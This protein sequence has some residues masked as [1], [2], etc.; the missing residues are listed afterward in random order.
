MLLASSIGLYI[1]TIYVPGVDIPLNLRG[2]ALVVIAL[3]LINLLIR[4]IV[5]L[6]FTPIII[7]TLGFGSIIVNAIMLYLLDFL[8]ATV[9]IEG[10]VALIVATLIISAS[11]IV[12]HILGKVL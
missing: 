9:T 8:L 4:P 11:S 5:R 2:F 3:T 6:A 12:V 7:L 10:L 1:A